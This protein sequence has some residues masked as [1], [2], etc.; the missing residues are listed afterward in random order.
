MEYPAKSR[1]KTLLLSISRL[2]K[3][4]D[5]VTIDSMIFD[6]WLCYCYVCKS[7]VCVY[8]FCI[9]CGKTF[10]SIHYCICPNSIEPKYYPRELVSRIQKICLTHNL[11][12]K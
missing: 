5:I 8:S 12:L 10:C 6:E 2:Q 4:N 7:N 3:N 1:L 11:G 9:N